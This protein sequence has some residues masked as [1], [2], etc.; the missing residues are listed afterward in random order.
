[1]AKHSSSQMPWAYVDGYKC[2]WAKE[3]NES[4]KNT[5]SEMNT[6]TALAT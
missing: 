1:M 2:E 4:K 3:K 5:S 6:K